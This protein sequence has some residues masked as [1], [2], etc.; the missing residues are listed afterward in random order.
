M[1]ITRWIH[2]ELKQFKMNLILRAAGKCV[3]NLY[4]RVSV[5]KLY[6]HCFEHCGFISLK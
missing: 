2:E 4:L 1:K 3:Y 5:S 6:F